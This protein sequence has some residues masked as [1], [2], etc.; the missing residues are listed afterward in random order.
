M[1]MRYIAALAPMAVTVAAQAQLLTTE[2]I[3]ISGSTPA[4]RQ[5]TTCMI[6][7]DGTTSSGGMIALQGASGVNVSGAHAKASDVALKFN[8]GAVVDSLNSTYGAGNWSVA[9][10]KLTFQYSLYT[11]SVSWNSGAGT[12]D[13]YWVGNDSWVQGSVNPAFAADASGLS[14]WSISQSL[15]GSEA[16]TWTTPTYTGTLNDLGTGAWALD[17]TG[18]K[19]STAAY[20]LGLNTSFLNDITSASAGSNPN[21]SLYLLTTSSSLGLDL[22]T[23]G[24]S[25]V[26]TLTFDVVAAPEPAS[27]ALAACGLAGFHAW[28]RRN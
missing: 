1:K 3:S 19:Q 13:I 17:K 6:S 12:F 11:T 25:S 24:G 15:L 14:V 18:A 20:G 2:S 4:G 22:F 27:L 5:Q 10:A 28:R 8:V 16:Y 21:V 7:S 9:N 26:P 23:G